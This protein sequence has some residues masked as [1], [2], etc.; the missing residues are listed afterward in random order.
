MLNIGDTPYMF[1]ARGS[2]LTRNESISQSAILNFKSNSDVTL[3]ECQRFSKTQLLNL[4]AENF[5]KN[6]MNDSSEM[7]SKKMFG[8]SS[9][10]MK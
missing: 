8:N 3:K 7:N 5:G 4:K 6:S 1:K 9:S 2:G 10:K